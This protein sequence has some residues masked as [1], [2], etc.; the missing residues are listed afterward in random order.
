[1]E[2][3]SFNVMRPVKFFKSVTSIAMTASMMLFMACSEDE[4]VAEET[5][6]FNITDFNIGDGVIL[7]YGAVN[8]IDFGDPSH[9]NYDFALYDGSYDPENDAFQGSFFMISELLSPGTTEFQEGA[10]TYI[11]PNTVAQ[12]SNSFYFNSVVILVDRNGNNTLFETEEDGLQDLMYF[13][14][15]GTIEVTD[16]GNNNYTLNYNLNLAEVDFTTE[17]LISNTDITLEFSV[18]RTFETIEVSLFGR[19]ENRGIFSG[20]R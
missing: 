4:P 20:K 3:Q 17:E 13:A 16:D 19:M 12:V 18:S 8:F 6:Q 9:Y 10:F 14:T 15:S 11:L 5:F 7:D 2:N 1:M